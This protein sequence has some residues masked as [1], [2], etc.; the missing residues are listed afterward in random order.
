MDILSIYPNICT[1][2]IWWRNAWKWWHQ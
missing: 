1:F 2:N